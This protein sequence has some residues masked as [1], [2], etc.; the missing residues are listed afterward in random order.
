[1]SII[2][3]AVNHATPATCADRHDWRLKKGYFI[4]I[5]ESSK[6]LG[7][8]KQARLDDRLTAVLAYSLSSIYKI[9][10]P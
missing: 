4:V 2:Q 6:A 7:S 5:C 3:S 1:M 9:E 8:S 10:D